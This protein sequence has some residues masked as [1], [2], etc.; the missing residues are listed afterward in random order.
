MEYNPRARMKKITNDLHKLDT[1]LGIVNIPIPETLYNEFI[2]RVG[3]SVSV[4][5]WI[6]ER[7]A[8][9]V[10]ETSGDPDIWSDEHAE[11]WWDEETAEELIRVGPP[12]EGFVWNNDLVLHNGTKIKMTYKKQDYFAEILHGKFMADN[13]KTPMTPSSWACRNANN[14]SR[15]AWRD[16]YIQTPDDDEFTWQSALECK[17]K[18]KKTW[19]KLIKYA[20]EH[21]PTNRPKK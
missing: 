21:Q 18:V 16:L 6:C 9:F 17:A 1:C 4:S 12:D 13:G 8:D 5:N 3:E 10:Y 2:L 15:N 11:E 19:E 14:T 20:E 7:I